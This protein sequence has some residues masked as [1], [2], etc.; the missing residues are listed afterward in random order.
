[1]PNET[2]QTDVNE[3]LSEDEMLDALAGDF[4]EEEDLPEQEVDDTEEAEEESDD[5]ES[6]ETEELEG[7]EQEEETEELEDDG[8][9]L[10]E[11]GSEEDSEL[12]LDY[13]VPIKIDGEV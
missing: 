4:F 5:A 13:L 7:E 8:E 3:G 10:P 12:D 11:D 1:M 6:D 2:T 9:D